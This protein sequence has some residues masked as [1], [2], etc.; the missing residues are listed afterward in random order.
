MPS[1]VGISLVRRFHCDNNAVVTIIENR[2]ARHMLLT[3]L[4]CCLFLCISLLFSLLCVTYIR[5]HNVVAD[6]ISHNNLTLVHS[7]IPQGSRVTIPPAVSTFLL[8]PPDWGSPAWTK[9]FTRS[10]PGLVFSHRWKLQV[11]CVPLF[12]FL[13]Q[14]LLSSLPIV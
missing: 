3:Q 14:I 2:N 4:L 1:N 7:L 8:T 11:R 12:S 9:Q 5:V 10:L 6:T 13:C